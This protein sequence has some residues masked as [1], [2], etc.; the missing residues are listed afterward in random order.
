[1]ELIKEIKFKYKKALSVN[2]IRNAQ[3]V[4]QKTKLKKAHMPRYEAIIKDNFEEGFKFP[5]KVH[6]EIVKRSRHDLDGIAFKYLWDLMTKLEFWH[7][8]NP[9]FV[10]KYSIEQNYNLPSDSFI[11]RFYDYT[12]DADKE[13]FMKEEFKEY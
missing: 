11:I 1:M 9:R 7:D 8:D 13:F 12:E 10:P 4:W 3:A 2:Q 6:I 5:E